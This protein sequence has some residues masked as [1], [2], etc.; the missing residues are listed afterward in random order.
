M[1]VPDVHEPP[2]IENIPDPA[3]C[4]SAGAAFKVRGPAYVPVALLVTEI[5]PVFVEVFAGELVSDGEGA[6]NCTVPAV[7]VPVSETD[8]TGVPLTFTF[9]LA[10]FGPAEADPFTPGA[11]LT[12]IVQLPPTPRLAGSV[13][14][15]LF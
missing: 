2:V 9:R 14:Q 11:K 15:L 10:L 4:V 7:A 6:L 5:V 12:L 3:V 8:C 13:P 1:T